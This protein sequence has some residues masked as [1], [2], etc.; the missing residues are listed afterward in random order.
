MKNKN[1][2]ENDILIGDSKNDLIASLQSGISFILFEGYKSS[3]SFPSKT[4]I[5]ENNLIR[6]EN[7]RTLLNTFM[8]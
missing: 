5:N 8:K 3:E 4:L 6:T 7:F 1:V 2:S